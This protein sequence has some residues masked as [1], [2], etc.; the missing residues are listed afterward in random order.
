MA[1]VAPYPH[2][3]AP[4]PLSRPGWALEEEFREEIDEDEPDDPADEEDEADEDRDDLVLGASR[5]FKGLVRR[6]AVD[7]VVRAETL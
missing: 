7:V 4:A 3:R 5:D 2:R 6:R 1:H